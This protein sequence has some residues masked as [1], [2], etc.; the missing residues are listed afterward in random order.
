MSLSNGQI[1]FD[2]EITNVTTSRDPG[3]EFL[4]VPRGIFGDQV[5]TQISEI[6]PN[7]PNGGSV[8]GNT[9]I[10]GLSLSIT[11][12]EAGLPVVDFQIEILSGG[13][14]IDINASFPD[15]SAIPT[16]D[17]DAK[18][19]V[20]E[21]GL[22]GTF[23][24]FGYEYGLSVNLEDG[25][26]IVGETIQ[27]GY[28]VTTSAGTYTWPEFD[29]NGGNL[30]DPP[31]GE[32]GD[33]NDPY[34][35]DDG[36]AAEDAANGSSDGGNTTG[37]GSTPSLEDVAGGNTTPSPGGGGYTYDSGG[38]TYTGD[39]TGANIPIILDLDGDGVEII[40]GESI[41]FDMDEDGFLEQTSWAAADD[42]FYQSAKSATSQ[43][44]S[45]GKAVFIARPSP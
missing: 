31:N 28:T 21:L 5:T 8:S 1:T 9:G 17:V 43:V 26:L 18:L 13:A 3:L 10:V 23:M 37:G 45:S 32:P 34:N 25:Q 7:N 6:D 24:G 16:I 27:S 11:S 19:D 14:V 22:G 2:S 15:G 44:A 42:G 30:P 29:P 4:G 38:V 40:F 36:S 33:P 20:P 12:D 41:Y 39:T 35:G